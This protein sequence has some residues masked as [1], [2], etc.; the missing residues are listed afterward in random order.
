MIKLGIFDHMDDSGVPLHDHFANR[1][2]VVEA[3]DRLGF[4]CYHVAE[5]HSTPLGVAASPG[6]YLSAVSQRTQQLRFGP[7][8]YLL[9]FYHPLRLVEEISMIDQL[10]GGRFQLGIGRGVSPFEAAFYNID[11]KNSREQYHEAYTV[12]MNGLHSDLINFDGQ[13]H[14]FKNVPMLLHPVQLPHPPLWYGLG[15]PE[16]AVWPAMHDVNVVMLGRRSVI[17]DIVARY[18]EV[19]A[20]LGKTDADLPMIGVSRHVVVADTDHE[21]MEIAR[22]AYPKWLHSF[23]WLWERQ[24]VD[25]GQMVKTTAGNYPDTFDEIMAVGNAIAGSPET[26]RQFIEEEVAATGINYFVSW[27]AFGDLTPEETIRSAELLAEV[28]RTVRVSGRPDVLAAAK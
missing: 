16:N 27:L 4:Y 6:I 25:V 21:A 28:G 9:P 15:T 23:K 19:R 11:F 12:V 13:F 5:H 2:K 17:R 7:L 24:G 10:S 20:E 8:V 22:R 3:Y 14:K 18:R 1:L 26:V